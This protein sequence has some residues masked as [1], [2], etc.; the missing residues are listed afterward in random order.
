VLVVF[1]SVTV[2]VILWFALPRRPMKRGYQGSRARANL[3]DRGGRKVNRIHKHHTAL[4]GRLFISAV[5]AVVAWVIACLSAGWWT[6][7]STTVFIV[8]FLIVYLL[9]T[10]LEA[11]IDREDRAARGELV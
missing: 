9:L 3:E 5:V 7:T 4:F 1:V 2:L 8:A 10:W 11:V 6:R